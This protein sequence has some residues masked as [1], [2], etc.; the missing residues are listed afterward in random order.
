M[1]PED[2]RLLI[3]PSSNVSTGP[4]DEVLDVGVWDI[5]VNWVSGFPEL[6]PGGSE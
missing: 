3:V 2:G 5:Y 6:R 4:G 1:H